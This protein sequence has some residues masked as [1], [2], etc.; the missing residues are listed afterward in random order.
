MLRP[1]VIPKLA[2]IHSPELALFFFFLNNIHPNL[3]EEISHGRFGCL[4][5]FCG[6]C[7]AIYGEEV[8]TRTEVRGQPWVSFL[9][10][11]P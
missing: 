5:P 9:R 3:C 4:H 7:S 11:H 10:H 1:H 6:C 8:Y 2:Y